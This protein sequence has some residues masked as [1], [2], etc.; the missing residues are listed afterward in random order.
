MVLWAQDVGNMGR[1]YERPA[2]EGPTQ[3]IGPESW[4]DGARKSESE[5]LYTLP[6]SVVSHPVLPANQ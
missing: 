1:Y 4:P 6:T 5:S 2:V 3:D